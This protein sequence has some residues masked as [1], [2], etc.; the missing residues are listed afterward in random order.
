MDPL[1]TLSMIVVYMAVTHSVRSR[2]VPNATTDTLTT[3]SDFVLSAE[4]ITA[5]PAP[6]QRHVPFA[7]K[8]ILCKLRLMA[9]SGVLVR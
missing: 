2:S 4:S 5:K 9:A 3:L 1:T 7:M 6:T 8:G